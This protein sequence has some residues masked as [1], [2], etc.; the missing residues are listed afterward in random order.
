MWGL[1]LYSTTTIDKAMTSQEAIKEF[2]KKAHFFLYM[3]TREATNKS[4]L[5]GKQRRNYLLIKGKK[6]TINATAIVSV[7]SRL[8]LHRLYLHSNGNLSYIV[9]IQVDVLL[10][11]MLLLS[12]TRNTHKIPS[13]PPLPS[14]HAVQYFMQQ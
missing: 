3:M 2:K 6:L 10:R 11:I 12:Y 1:S 7:L 9:P 14:A 13:S 8:N 5:F 4:A